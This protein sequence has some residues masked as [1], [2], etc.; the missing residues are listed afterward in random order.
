MNSRIE[1]LLNQPCLGE[2][3]G[4][5]ASRVRWSELAC[6]RCRT[7]IVERPP[8]ILADPRTRRGRKLMFSIVQ[9]NVVDASSHLNRGALVHVAGVRAENRMALRCDAPSNQGL[10]ARVFHRGDHLV[11]SEPMPAQE[12][13]NVISQDRAHVASQ[14]MRRH[15]S[16]QSV[17]EGLPVSVVPPE[18][19]QRESFFRRLVERPKFRKRRL[20]RFA[21]LMRRPQFGDLRNVDFVGH[22]P[23]RIVG[24]PMTVTRED[25]MMRDCHHVRQ[26]IQKRRRQA[27]C[28][29]RF[30][31]TGNVSSAFQVNKYHA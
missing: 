21:P 19:G 23:A 9:P 11:P 29:S 2:L 10:A 13:M 8:V 15:N 4:A 5:M 30:L 31:S 24:Q 25:N 22:A 12:Q 26:F 6:R 16:A 28:R 7:F 14:P 27:S 20:D 18:H 3:T 1:S 17:G